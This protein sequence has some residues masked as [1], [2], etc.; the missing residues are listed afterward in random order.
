MHKTKVFF[1]FK[2]YDK[3]IIKHNYVVSINLIDCW[4]NC[5]SEQ[6]GKVEF[7]F[8]FLSYRL[9]GLTMITSDCRD[10][11]KQ[12]DNPNVHNVGMNNKFLVKMRLN[13][14]N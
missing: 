9:I 5:N 12:S 3:C 7:V 4:E 2:S 14:E 1:Y 6:A 13:I 10:L 8:L 11:S